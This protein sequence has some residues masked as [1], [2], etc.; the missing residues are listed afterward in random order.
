MEDKNLPESPTGEDT[1]STILEDTAIT[2]EYN[3]IFIYASGLCQRDY[4]SAST[5]PEFNFY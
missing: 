5:T 2:T 1:I 4:E 3:G